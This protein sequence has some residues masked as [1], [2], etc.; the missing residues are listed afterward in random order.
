[1]ESRHTYFSSSPPGFWVLN[2]FWKCIRILFLIKIWFSLGS[3]PIYMYCKTSYTVDWRRRAPG[4]PNCN[5]EKKFNPTTEVVTCHWR[6]C[7]LFWV[8]SVITSLVFRLGLILS[9][10]YCLVT[11]CKLVTRCHA[12]TVGPTGTIAN[13][14]KCCKIRFIGH[15]S[16]IYGNL[17]MA[18]G[19]WRVYNYDNM[20]FLKH[21]WLSSD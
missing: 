21:H 18:I 2:S 19:S 11:F 12:K 4:K 6:K 3:S 20:L 16:N 9:I 8:E 1:M 17:H 14:C 7:I 10:L 5:E 13:C 15:N